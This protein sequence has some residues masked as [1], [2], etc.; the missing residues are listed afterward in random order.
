MRNRQTTPRSEESKHTHTQNA[1]DV[2]GD[3][4]DGV[5][6]ELSEYL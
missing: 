4:E 3:V 2:D 5:G 1:V 6:Y